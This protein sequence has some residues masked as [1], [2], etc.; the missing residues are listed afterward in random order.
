MSNLSDYFLSNQYTPA[1]M[2]FDGSTGYYSKSGVTTT[3]NKV[4]IVGRFKCGSSTDDQRIVTAVA[5]GSL[6]I[7]IG[8]KESDHASAPNLL[9]FVC[10]TAAAAL[11]AN[12]VTSVTVTDNLEHTFL[13]AYD[14]DAG[15][16][17]IYIDGASVIDTGHTLHSL[18]AGTLT[19]G[20]TGFWVG[21]SNSPSLYFNGEI[22]FIG[23]H[24]AYI[25]DPTLFFN[26]ANNVKKLD[27][28]G[29]TEWTTQPLFW[30]EHANMVNNLGTAGNMTKNGTII[31]GKGGNS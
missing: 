14:G 11:L 27:E 10:Y 6:R 18:S 16:A 25:T 12:V 13:V 1:M 29:W 23:I 26:A 30:N 31:V 21:S 2:E 24:D 17:V 4:T 15:T 8:V 7:Q 5:N 28:S 20:S 19:T 22:G 9:Q 3:G